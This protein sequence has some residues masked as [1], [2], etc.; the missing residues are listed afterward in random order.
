MFDDQFACEWFPNVTDGWIDQT[1]DSKFWYTIFLI[2]N[3]K[4]INRK[5]QH[6]TLLTSRT[7]CIDSGVNIKFNGFE[8]FVGPEL[9]RFLIEI[10]RLFVGRLYSMK[11]SI[12][13]CISLFNIGRFS[14]HLSRYYRRMEIWLLKCWSSIQSRHWPEWLWIHHDMFH[15]GNGSVSVLV[16]LRTV[17]PSCPMVADRFWKLQQIDWLMW[18]ALII[19]TN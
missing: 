3:E 5:E 10:S 7:F 11:N 14:S 12:T 2:I 16:T 13:F 1:F 19:K 6:W 15:T 4:Y 8:P 18:L 9:T 17:F